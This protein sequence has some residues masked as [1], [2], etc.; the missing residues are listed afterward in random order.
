VSP[1]DK[2][3]VNPLLRPTEPQPETNTEASTETPTKTHTQ[4]STET[5]TK[6]PME[7]ITQLP[8]QTDTQVPTVTLTKM[9]VETPTNAP[10]QTNTSTITSASTFTSTDDD[11]DEPVERRKRGKQA[12]DKIHMRW[13][14]WINKKLK[15]RIDQLSKEQEVSLV[16]LAEE[17]FTDLLKKYGK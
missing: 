17:A 11:I 16:A 4:E 13:T 1:K 5:P 10:T 12:F 3:F 15:K 2:K 7:T 14:L 8:T 6:V 9:P